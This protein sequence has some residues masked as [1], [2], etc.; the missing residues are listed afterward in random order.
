MKNAYLRVLHL[1]EKKYYSNSYSIRTIRKKQSIA[2]EIPY[3]SISTELA[4]GQGFRL[5]RSPNVKDL[6]LGLEIS[7]D[8]FRTSISTGK[9]F[10][11]LRFFRKG[12][13]SYVYIDLKRSP[14]NLT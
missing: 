14:S 13:P 5:Q 12:T 7:A 10:T 6:I 9:L 1:E 11:L 4:Y 8:N 3:S 2:L